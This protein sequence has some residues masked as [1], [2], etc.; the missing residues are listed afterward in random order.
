M[1]STYTLI[2]GETLTTTA[3]SYSFTAIPSTFTDLVL[4]ISD[5][6]G[7]TGSDAINMTFNSDSASNYSNIYIQGNGAS[8]VSGLDSSV[9]RIRYLTD[10]STN[11]A[12]T[13]GSTEIYIPSYNVSQNKP[14][15]L[16]NTYE[17]NSSTAYIRGIANLWRNTAAI[18][19]ITLTPQSSTF[20]AGSSFYLYGIKNS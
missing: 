12:S 13:F 20:V 16:F 10:L 7:S 18:T 2:K 11:T 17:N 5:R 1:P 4:R 3:A 6:T 15:S 9:A 8:A 14:V 19:S